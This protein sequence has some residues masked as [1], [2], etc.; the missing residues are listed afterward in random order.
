MSANSC[1]LHKPHS[2]GAL[3]GYCS[4]FAKCMEFVGE[5]QDLVM[6]E[7][8]WIEDSGEAVWCR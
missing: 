7:D 2:R 5:N 6:L 1:F 3:C 8:N 4:I